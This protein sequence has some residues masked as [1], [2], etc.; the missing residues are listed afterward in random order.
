[1]FLRDFFFKKIGELLYGLGAFLNFL[2][3]CGD[4]F[5]TKWGL[6]PSHASEYIKASIFV[7]LQYTVVLVI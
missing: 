6:E 4:S 2:G 3:N 1:M 7:L 5:K